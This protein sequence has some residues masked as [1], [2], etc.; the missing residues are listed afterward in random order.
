[1]STFLE[2]CQNVHE[3][4]TIQ[5]TISTVEATS[6]PPYLARLVAS[7]VRKAWIY[8][9]VRR[10]DWLFMRK[11]HSNFHLGSSPKTSYTPTEVFTN[12]GVTNDLAS[13]YPAPMGS[14]FYGTKG[15]AYIP[16]LS[17]PLIE[18]TVAGEP[19]WY[20]FD[21]SNNLHI[22]LCNADYYLTVYYRR[23]PQVLSSNTDSPFI[24]SEWHELIEY[25]GLKSFLLKHGNYEIWQEYEEKANTLYGRL[26]RAFVPQKT[27]SINGGLV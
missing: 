25:E 6:D 17:L 14:V 18:N 8:L 7:S 21:A 12:V 4:S 3:M 2:M 11:S 27:F 20:S 10:E 13:Y 19:R 16:F 15:L 22:N 9:Q 24:P 23:T 1:M 5:G 26:L